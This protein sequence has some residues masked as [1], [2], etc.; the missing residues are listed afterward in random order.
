MKAGETTAA[1]ARESE[2]DRR[3]SVLVAGLVRSAQVA[4]GHCRC[5]RNQVPGLPTV[6]RTHAVPAGNQHLIRRQDSAF[7]LQGCLLAGVRTAERLPDLEH[8]GRLH[9]VLDP[10][11][12]VHA[13][14]LHQD[15]VL[16][17]SVLFDDRFAH[18]Q[19]VNAISDGLNRLGHGAIFEVGQG[20]RLHGNSP[21]VIRA[22]GQ[23]VLGKAILHDGEQVRPGFWRHAFQHN[24][25]GIVGRIGFADL[26]VVDL[27]SPQIGLQTFDRVVRI[28]ID[29]II[30]LHLQD[31]VSAA[32]Q[33][34][35]EVNAVL[36]CS[37]GSARPIVR[38]AKNAEHE[39]QQRGDNN[40]KFPAQ[41]LIH[42]K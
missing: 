40:D 33:V 1:L 25:V 11:G 4:A 6:G 38:R 19:L 23:L 8:G 21:G 39:E 31:Q 16:P 34:E 22:R 36:Q 37:E 41:V 12:I 35:S 13:R 17:K 42:E 7:I 5:A 10:R 3:L 2:T 18:T 28:Y 14:Q 20:L 27:A 30:H 26:G 15:L 29:G 24:L 9:D 32:L